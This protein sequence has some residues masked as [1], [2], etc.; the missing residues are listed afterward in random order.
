MKDYGAIVVGCDFSR[1]GDFDTLA[2]GTKKGNKVEVLNIIQGNRA[3][4]LYEEL[5]TYKEKEKQDGSGQ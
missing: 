5:T 3:R 1:G 2:V 4:E